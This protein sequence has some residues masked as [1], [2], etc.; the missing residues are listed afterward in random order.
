[1]LEGGN[2]RVATIPAVATCVVVSLVAFRVMA[3]GSTWP[4][5]TQWDSSLA[6]VVVASASVALACLIGAAI[7]L[8]VVDSLAEIR[9][10]AAWTAVATGRWSGGLVSEREQADNIYRPAIHDEAVH[11]VLRAHRYDLPR[12]SV[13]PEIDRRHNQSQ[14]EPMPLGCALQSPAARSVE[15]EIA[16]SPRRAVI[17]GGGAD[18][19]ATVRSA[20]TEEARKAWAVVHT[21]APVVR[22]TRSQRQ[23]HHGAR[24]VERL[25]RTVNARTGEDW[26]GAGSS[27][28]VAGIPV[29]L[30]SD[31]VVLGQDQNGSDDSKPPPDT[32]FKGA[33]PIRA[34]PPTTIARST[35]RS[36]T[37]HQ[38]NESD[39][40]DLTAL[41]EARRQVIA[42]AATLA[43]QAAREDDAAEQRE[44]RSR[45]APDM[46][47][48]QSPSR[49]DQDDMS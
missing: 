32:R 29:R 44:G 42:L 39:G 12:I 49:G 47:T 13:E 41:A 25:R 33:P 18:H 24:L 9:S 36:R 8:L 26:R 31:I 46:P 20:N 7:G 10:R 4:V 16:W 40:F 5:A 23:F 37:R 45:S 43:R 19:G 14:A 1:M 34:G 17:G 27:L 3:A 6:M 30:V 48:Q 38:P 11:A 2:T 22:A 28:R 21:S 35:L 15:H